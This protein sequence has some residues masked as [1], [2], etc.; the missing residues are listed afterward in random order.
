MIYDFLCELHIKPYT[1]LG[2]MPRMLASR[3]QFANWQHRPN[4]S[5]PRSLKNWSRL[6]EHFMEHLIHRYGRKE[7]LTWKS[8]CG[9]PRIWK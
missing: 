7:V 8:I 2:F 5:F 6:V 9:P 4:V 1:E 3:Q